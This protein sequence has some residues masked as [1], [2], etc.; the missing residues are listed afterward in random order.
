[1]PVQSVLYHRFDKRWTGV[2]EVLL[3]LPNS[4]QRG[5]IDV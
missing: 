4:S 2:T 1:M 5:A 3:Y